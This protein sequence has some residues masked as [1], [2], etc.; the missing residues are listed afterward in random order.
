MN[1]LYLSNNRWSGRDYE[2]P[3]TNL[4]ERGCPGLPGPVDDGPG[5]AGPPAASLCLGLQGCV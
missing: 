5:D 4:A 1:T 3:F 2:T